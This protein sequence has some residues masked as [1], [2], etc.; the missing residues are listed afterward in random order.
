MKKCHLFPFVFLA[1]FTAC[2][3]GSEE[4]PLPA[5][6]CVS[7]RAS[8]GGNSRATETAFEYGDA[9]SVFAVDPVEGTE[10]KA[11]GNY[12]DNIKYAYQGG[13]FEAVNDGV[14]VSKNHPEGLAYYVV[15]P[16]QST[17]SD[18]FHFAV[19]TNQST[20]ANYTLSDLCTAYASPT[21][22]NMV[23][24]EFYHR[25]CNVQV[26]FEGDNLMSRD[27]KV[28]LE[29]IY[30]GC[31]VDINSSTF[32]AAGNRGSV[33]MGEESDNTFHA[34]AV[35]QTLVGGSKF[36]KVTMDNRDFWF[37]L[38]SNKTIKSGCAY[39]F[40]LRVD[41][42]AVN[43]VSGN[44][45][46]WEEESVT[47]DSGK[48]LSGVLIERSYGTA[49][50]AFVYDANG[51]LVNWG[52]MQMSDEGESSDTYIYTLDWNGNKCTETCDAD[53]DIVVHYTF[54]DNMMKTS[55]WGNWTQ[56][57]T[58]DN[59]G[60]LARIDHS[61]SDSNDTRRDT[62]YWENGKLMK[63][64]T[65]DGSITLS[66]IDKK[67]N[68]YNPAIFLFSNIILEDVNLALPCPELV[69]LRMNH[70]VGRITDDDGYVYDF[71]YELD[72][73]GYIVGCTVQTL[74]LGV[75]AEVYVFDWE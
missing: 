42:D 53:A 24:L 16:Y 38:R 54:V 5:E 20:H 62:Y 32:Q 41:G 51:R 11:S 7:F 44:L 50:C 75:K 23:D 74:R 34:I 48:R 71:S 3:D 59:A 25:L 30:T 69:G 40:T 28:Q 33:V 26:K 21:T 43:A 2:T 12:A 65:E 68:G 35:P 47:P 55:T 49:V 60:Q 14:T 56:T 66:Y 36:I 58:Y 73:E 4:L 27:I 13:S 15:Y 39:S 1:L 29:G 17:A 63:I 70:L 31:N 9:I 19:K 37:K 67:I 10:L 8:F 52:G 46:S 45:E 64:A 57:F 72:E 61:Y 6:D 22:D 18:E